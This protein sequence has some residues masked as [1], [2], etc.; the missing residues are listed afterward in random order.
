MEVMFEIPDFNVGTYGVRG[1][2]ANNIE[3]DGRRTTLE[4][5]FN[6]DVR[7]DWFNATFLVETNEP[8]E[9]GPINIDS[10]K[11][12]KVVY[13]KNGTRVEPSTRTIN[14]IKDRTNLFL[15]PIRIKTIKE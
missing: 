7:Y 6:V 14:N 2:S 13:F 15:R 8:L 1:V 4:I 5:T 3:S 11:L 12:I 9:V 10:A